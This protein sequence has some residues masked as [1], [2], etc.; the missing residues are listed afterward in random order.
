MWFRHDLSLAMPDPVAVLG[1]TGNIGSACSD[2]LLARGAQV[3]VLGR[4]PD[5]MRER[6]PG[7][8]AVRFDLLEPATFAPALRGA[9]SLFVIR[10][11]AASNVDRAL[12]AFLDAAE[13]A[14]VEHVVFSSVA[15]AEERAWLPHARIERHLEG[16]TLGATLL[17]PGFFMQNLEDAYRADIR[18]D[19]R[20]Y[21]PAGRARV[22]WIDTRDI[23]D[24]AAVCLLDSATHDGR[25]YHLTG[26]EA[27]P[28]V[29]V[30]DVLARV[31]GRP[32]RYDAA[33]IAGYLWHLLVRRRMGVVQAL[34]QTYLHA[35]L[36]R[37]TA[38]PVTPD[39]ERLL[40]RPPRTVSEY[41][42]DHASVWRR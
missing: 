23:G 22:A 24:A 14:G 33:S 30:V 21:V 37:G 19:D 10:P 9:R 4:D 38:E 35:D 25:A 34:V 6:F 41:V 39:L 31:L 36:R 7:A 15:G 1:A 16:L 13:Q 17:R 11:P 42:R 3:R 27:L 32:I 12:A 28:F 40:G 29:Q 18:D 5:R 20:I 8:D 2:A 26:A